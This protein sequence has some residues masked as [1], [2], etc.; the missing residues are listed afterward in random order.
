MT[1]IETCPSFSPPK[2]STFLICKISRYMDGSVYCSGEMYASS[3]HFLNSRLTSRNFRNSVLQFFS[4]SVSPSI[5]YNRFVHNGCF[6]L[7]G[8]LELRESVNTSRS[9]ISSTSK[10]SRRKAIGMRLHK[11]C[12]ILF[13]QIQR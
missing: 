11:V 2:L 3:P 6:R 1:M 7:N 9:G 10:S 13:A 4:V 5:K 12:R 8:R